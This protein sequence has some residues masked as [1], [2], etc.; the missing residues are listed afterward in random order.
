MKV[1]SPGSGFGQKPDTRKGHLSLFT[2]F[3]WFRMEAALR[4]G[5]S[6]GGEE[7]EDWGEEADIDEGTFGLRKTGYPARPNI[8][9]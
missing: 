1:Q 6:E 2:N 7:E 8:L 3:S 5:D 9:K 4:G